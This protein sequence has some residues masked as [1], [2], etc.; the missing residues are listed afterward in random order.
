M[1]NDAT[2]R[3]I[4]LNLLLQGPQIPTGGSVTSAAGPASVTAVPE[5]SA[6]LV[7]MMTA[8]SAT[9]TRHR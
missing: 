4:D 6:R 1:M 7:A 8:G 9:L 2:L 3:K 5:P